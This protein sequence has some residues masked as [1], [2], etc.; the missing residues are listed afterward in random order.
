MASHYEDFHLEEQDSHDNEDKDKDKKDS[1]E[2]LSPTAKR[3]AEGWYLY[4]LLEMKQR[5]LIE[6]MGGQH[7][8]MN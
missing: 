5:Y 1:E 2:R 4:S 8:Y 7:E 3:L 6:G